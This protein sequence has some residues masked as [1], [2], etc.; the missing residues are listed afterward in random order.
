MVCQAKKFHNNLYFHLMI[1]GAETAIR[2][3]LSQDKVL[4]SL[5][6]YKIIFVSYLSSANGQNNYHS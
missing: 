5:L 1:E 6:F 4:D 3:I 2:D